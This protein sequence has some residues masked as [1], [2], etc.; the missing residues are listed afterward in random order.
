[1]K[2]FDYAATTP[3][4]DE[5]IQAFT[6]AARLA[7]GNANSLHD[8]GCRS[9]EI[10]NFCR[11]YMATIFQT[12]GDSIIFTSGGTE[13][14]RLAIQ[15]LLHN[16]DK[17]H[18]I[19]S[20]L[21]HSSILHYLQ[22]LKE[23]GY[24]IDFVNH[25]E[26]GTVCLQHLEQLIQESTALVIIQHGNSEIGTIQPISDIANILKNSDAALH[27]DC[28]QTFCKIDCSNIAK[29]ASTISVSSHKLYGPKGVGAIISPQIDRLN[30]IN[31]LVT[32]EYGFRPG[33][34]NVPGI[35]SFATAIKQAL[36]TMT[37]DH[38]H[39]Q[40]LRTYFVKELQSSNCD[41]Q[42]IESL[43][44]LP[45]IICLLF[46]KVQGQYVMMELNKRGYCVSSGSA[47]QAGSKEPSKVLLAIG[48]NEDEAKSSI[49][50]SLGKNLTEEQCRD[51]A[52]SIS[53]IISSID[54]Q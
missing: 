39:I 16:T 33:T 2:Y 44:Q 4:S 10:L 36:Q 18:I 40:H 35:F 19:T 34:V 32:H 30:P 23:Q 7:F 14:N 49:R 9:L 17:K 54:S 21:E 28:V 24:T 11:S 43:R 15:T 6:E 20:S 29:F 31:N 22:E 12:E 45:H 41:F 1:M 8:I 50:I 47:C 51:L 53:S 52:A 37:E 13:S 48:K 27:I 38:R 46:S 42:L 26:D 25:L 3:M 5:A